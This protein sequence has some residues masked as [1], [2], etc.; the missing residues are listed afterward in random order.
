MMIVS[1]AYIRS[2]M[3]LSLL[4]AEALL[5]V[6]GI[7]KMFY[8]IFGT[9]FGFLISVSLGYPV[10]FLILTAFART[11]PRIL[12]PTLVTSYPDVF[13]TLGPLKKRDSRSG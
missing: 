6:M 13:T 9:Y 4:T 12:A 10:A 3:F 8:P 11:I 1:P 7:R 5:W 2:V